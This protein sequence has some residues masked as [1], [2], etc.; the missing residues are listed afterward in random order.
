MWD[1][2]G[3]AHLFFILCFL[4]TVCTKVC[5]SSGYFELQLISVEN[6]RG[7]LLN[8]DCCDSEGRQ[9]DGNCGLDECDTYFRVCLKEYQ[10]E[11]KIGGP[12][13][14]GLEITKVIGGNTF[15]FRGSQKGSH[16]TGKIVIPFQFSWPSSKPNKTCSSSLLG[17]AAW[18]TGSAL[19]IRAARNCCHTKRS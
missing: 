1:N 16:D 11:V 14:Y 6:P 4:L 3:K 8:G 10:Q 9:A 2:P 17:E 7:Q 18:E 19:A 5:Q 13:T 12:C 15:Q